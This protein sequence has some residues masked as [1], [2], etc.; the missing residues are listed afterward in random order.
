M[1]TV[2]PRTQRQMDGVGMR[3]GSG[4]GAG[5]GIGSSRR[6]ALA[7]LGAVLLALPLFGCGPGQYADAPAVTGVSAAEIVGTWRCVDGTEV[8]MRAD[9]SA[10][11]KQ[12]DGQ[13][14]DFDDQWRMSG[15][16]TW[17]LTDRPM[18]WSDGQHVSLRVTRRT[19]SAW[20]K[21][22]DA[23]AGEAVVGGESR[24]PAPGSYT[25]TLELE[26]RKKGLALYFFFSDPDS[27]NTYYLEKA[28]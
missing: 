5:V 14:F 13:E 11:V 22:A 26:R 20:R 17:E 16:G 8:T 27:R 1:I 6:G 24:A 28:R 12:L 21:P 15:T 4:T 19:S 2:R 10:V 25:W 18:G 23:V 9:G 3:A 7:G